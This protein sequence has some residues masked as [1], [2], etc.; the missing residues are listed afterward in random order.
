MELPLAWR[1]QITHQWEEG[2][3]GPIERKSSSNKEGMTRLPKKQ[4]CKPV[5]GCRAKSSDLKP[6][7][8][9]GLKSDIFTLEALLGTYCTEKYKESYKSARFRSKFRLQS[10]IDFLGRFKSRHLPGFWP[11]FD[12]HTEIR[13]TI[14]FHFEFRP[15]IDW[16]VELPATVD[17]KGKVEIK[18][19]PRLGQRQGKP[20]LRGHYESIHEWIRIMNMNEYK[21]IH[22]VLFHFILL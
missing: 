11:T 16:L 5:E 4:S 2:I 22:T 18:S 15:T 7:R 20:V 10:T 8:S 6:E 19:T 3:S 9:E 21:R 14:D 17:Y 13:P 1:V 12:C